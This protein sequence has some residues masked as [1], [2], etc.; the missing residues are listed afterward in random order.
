M[1]IELI[2]VVISFVITLNFSNYE[3]NL[4]L[5]LNSYLR[6][7]PLAL[8]LLMLVLFVIELRF[9]RRKRMGRLI[10]ASMIVL[11]LVFLSINKKIDLFNTILL[12]IDLI[13]LVLLIIEI[14]KS[15]KHKNDNNE[16]PEGY[17]RKKSLFVFNFLLV[18]CIILYALVLFLSIYYKKYYLIPIGLLLCVILV[19]SFSIFTLFKDN[20][21]IRDFCKD[22]DYD[23]FARRL[24]DIYA[25]NLNPNT[26]SAVR[27]NEYSAL[28]LIDK[29]KANC[30]FL[31]ISV[32]NS[33]LNLDVYNHTRLLYLA[34]NGFYEEF[35]IFVK[36]LKLNKDIRYMISLKNTLALSASEAELDLYFNL[37]TN[38]KYNYYFNCYVRYLYYKGL[39]NDKYLEYE[40]L[41]K[42]DNNK[43]LETKKDL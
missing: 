29:E 35:D 15:D 32:P 27:C 12:I 38:K 14:I 40:L 24:S 21:F 41:L 37:K 28:C 1:Y 10:L 17:L 13:Y 43:L 22:L 42:Q 18:C 6:F 11:M 16:L 25:E 3:E 34:L 7:I 26:L 36:K 19:F 8:N 4:G 39:N 31:S 20:R 30:L 33:K 23:K 2:L 9:G 5:V